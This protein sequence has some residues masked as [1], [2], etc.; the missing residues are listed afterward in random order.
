MQALSGRSACA[1]WF[2]WALCY[3]IGATSLTLALFA[4]NAPGAFWI[5]LVWQLGVLLQLGLTSANLN[6][7]ALEP[8]GHIAGATSSVIGSVS[9]VGGAIIAAAVAPL[10][11]G[12]PVPLFWVTLL[13]MIACILLL[14]TMHRKE[15][16]IADGAS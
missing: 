6:S 11:N 5:Y 2:V 15:A 16:A 1:A 8:M 4:L 12:T 9:I 10:F 7:L 14:S 3:Q 13:L